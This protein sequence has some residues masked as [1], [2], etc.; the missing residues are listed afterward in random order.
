MFNDK[1]EIEGDARDEVRE[2]MER[3]FSKKIH[4]DINL[5]L[6]DEAFGFDNLNQDEMEE[7][8]AWLDEGTFDSIP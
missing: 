7:Y 8:E 2:A 1:L 6:Q 3:D 4:E 5:D